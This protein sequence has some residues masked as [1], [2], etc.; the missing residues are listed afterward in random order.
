ME[1]K[2]QNTQKKRSD[3]WLSEAGKLVEE[4]LEEGGHKVQTSSYKIN[5]YEGSKVH[6]GDYSL[7]CYLIYRKVHPKSFHHQ[8]N[9]F[10]FVLHFYFI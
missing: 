6:H 1:F 4:E 7:Y 10:C 2:K 3:L 5:K 9:Y 8:E